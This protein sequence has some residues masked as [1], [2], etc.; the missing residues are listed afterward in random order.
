VKAAD[1]HRLILCFGSG[2][3]RVFDVTPLLPFGRFRELA[4]PE[5]FKKVRVAYDTVEWENGLDL[6]PEYLY[7]RSQPT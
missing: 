3:Q 6:D 7:E 2:E 1:G 5:V 4:V